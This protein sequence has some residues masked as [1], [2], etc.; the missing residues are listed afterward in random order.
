[1]ATPQTPPAVLLHTQLDHEIEGF[2]LLS[3]VTGP[4]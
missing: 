2:S 1:M 3:I 4:C